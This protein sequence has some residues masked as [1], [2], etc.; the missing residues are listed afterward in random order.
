[1]PKEKL[2]ATSA[3]QDQ[4][5]AG[6]GEMG[7]RMR[8]FDW[9]R[10]PLGPVKGWP[11][12][13]RTCVRIVLTSRQPMFVW[14]GD[15]LINIYNDAYR[16]IVGGKHPEALGQPASVVW[17]EIWD[18]V[19]PRAEAAMRRNEGT[20]DE[21][22]LL[23]MER[24]G[25]PE[26]TYYTFSYSPV[27]NDQG[28]TGGIICANTD[29]TQRLI[30]E[31][32]LALLRDLAAS[33][34]EARTVL[35]ACALAARALA[36]NPRDLPFALVYLIEPDERSAVLAGAAGIEPGHAAAPERF[37]LDGGGPWPVGEVNR[38]HS[39]KL[40][41][42]LAARFGGASLP[43]GAWP[44]SPERAAV[45]PVAA[46]GGSGRPVV[47]VVGLNPFRPYDDEMRSF[48]SLVAAQ[49]S[50]AVGNANA[51][52]EEKKRA[53][54]LAE[55]DRAKTAF[56]SNVSHEFRTPLTLMLGPLQD[57]L[58]GARGPLT[59][60]VQQDL[61]VVHRNAARLLKL[62]N[63]LLDFSRIEAGRMQ[64]SY[65]PVD[66]ATFTAELASVFR[67][68]I[69]RAGLSFDVRCSPLGQPVYVDRVMW[70]R[71]VLNLL[72]NAFKFTFQGGIEVS[73]RLEDGAA[74][75]RVTD[76]GVGVPPAEVPRLF[77]RFHRVEGTRARTHEGSGIGLALVQE[78]VKMHGGA[79]H[80]ESTLG[81]GTT[82]TVTVPL[83][84]AH[85]PRAQVAAGA[86]SVAPRA[87]Q[88]GARADDVGARAYADEALRWLPEEP[89]PPSETAVEMTAPARAPDGAARI[90]LADDNADMREYVARVLRER[91]RVDAVADGAAALAACH[92]EPA[93]LVLTDVMMPN[94]DGFGLLRELRADPNTRATP[95][96][97]LSARAGEEA[98]VEGLH[99]GAD[100]YLIKPFSA[101][102]L[103]ARVETHLLL[104]RLR[105]AAETERARLH[106]IFTNAP[107]MI[108]I[109]KGPQHV[110]ELANPL[111]M[112]MV[113]DRPVL[114]RPVREAV[115]E[116][117]EQG[118]VAILDRVY[119]T[120]EP[121]VGREVPLK[122]DRS[123]TGVLEHVFVN[124]VYQ[125]SFAADGQVEGV[126]FF[127]FEVTD[128]VVARLKVEDEHRAAEAAR[129]EAEAA[130]RARDDFLSIAS[131]ELRTPLTSL[132]LQADGALRA[133]RR[134]GAAASVASTLAK[135][136]KIRVQ[137]RRL[138][139][140]VQ[141]LL[142]VTR[143]AAGRLDLHLEE[144]DLADVARDVCERLR[145]QAER[146][147]SAVALRVSGTAHG[148]LKGRWD[149]MRLDQVLTNLL[150]NAI[151]YGQGRPIALEIEPSA[152][153]DVVC[154]RVRD[155][156]MGIAPEHQSRIF[157]RFERVV[158]DRHL[159]GIGLGLWIA[160]QF[161][162]TMGGTISV[163]STVNEGST[164]SVT[165][166]VGERLRAPAP[167]TACD[168][169]MNG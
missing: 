2:A 88:A 141:G 107:A 92:A 165:L 105:V 122:V 147:G 138:E 5:L 6:G 144:V 24:N 29:D 156:G 153:G 11:Q 31:R 93:D 132:C 58:A 148:A 55:L 21:A 118:F 12:T 1:M 81:A 84:A 20:Y 36:T 64:A 124:F 72:S 76:S 77:E 70:E 163:A 135:V 83:G 104:S 109:L 39:P 60:E 123:G 80:A 82:F 159:G 142:D 28:G 75:L 136:E 7:A 96:I 42:E 44:R 16:A 25:Y 41:A 66:L 97:M 133:L 120:G 169:E 27:P 160:R 127:A 37:A 106:G 168:S 43:A 126:I 73:L 3:E 40:V 62:V 65:E 115:P 90:V 102:E 149:A 140:L 121:Y 146:S 53:E 48:L 47:L 45:I 46:S 166:P 57:Q 71:I 14:W 61:E 85:L 91:W 139:V 167:K 32:R 137:A 103:V 117:V 131:H 94:L 59:P 19:G 101:R 78:L 128:Q 151:K 129:T 154:V 100:D 54:A 116:L 51:Y 87:D 86:E 162:E 34:A 111:C 157:E 9:S 69:E 114:G 119:R 108:G 143:L 49:I 155:H 158:P 89:A 18:Q 99:A 150:S 98:K 4:V 26:E 8:A 15:A 10:T 68:A 145:D 50:A 17:R 23:I 38:A 112:Q 125:P 63:S 134:E 161:I 56:F 33:T 152:A 35:D 110:F 30:G 130:V 74:A 79:I 95:V 164:F 113:G 67:S 52:E 13:L 22:L